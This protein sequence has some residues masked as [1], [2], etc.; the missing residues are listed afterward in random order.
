MTRG[1]LAP[2]QVKMMKT[3]HTE[4]SKAR[5]GE[6]GAALVTALLVSL[7]MLA[8][9]GALVIST[10]MSASN[11]VDATAEAQAF[12]AADAGL[13]AALNVL[14]RNKPALGGSTM[15]A[16]F[17]N[18]V[19]GS[20]AA[21]NND[22]GNLSQWLTYTNGAVKL[23]EAGAALPFT[24]S[25]TLSVSDPSLAAGAAVTAS[26]QPRYLLVRSTGRGPKGA[27]KVLEMM[28]D[29][30]QFDY[31]A[32]APLVL[33]QTA[34]ATAH[35]S[36]DPGS[37]GPNYSGQDRVSAILKGAVGAGTEVFD[38]DTDHAIA[39]AAMGTVTTTGG[40]IRMG[41]GVGE[42]PWP[43]PVKT[44]AQARTFLSEAQE[45][46]QEAALVGAGYNGGCPGNSTPLNGMI[47]IDG[48]CTLNPGNSGAGFMVTNGEL[49]LSGSY[50]FEGL[51]FVLGGGALRRN[52]GGGTTN[53][54]LY[55]GILAA[56]FGLASGDFGGVV[57]NT[58]GG[59]GSVIQYD[60]QAIANALAQFGPKVLGVVEK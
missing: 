37:G 12:Y 57:F 54:Q 25:Y 30:F 5:A 45:A 11:A 18:V 16:D 55:G 58:N 26:Y 36:I 47:F 9:G 22:G 43:S 38:S 32:P 44:T 8:A 50:N 7:L 24:L 10:G 49:T 56:K 46:A 42:T 17:H 41:S 33:R 51:I 29:R 19:C 34:N 1:G 35:L 28:V 52:G 40:V 3:R 4:L 53:G 6:R 14:R 31:D 21:C 60:S 15:K 48:D 27:T 23:S 20:A 59:G 39:T 2:L 13:Q